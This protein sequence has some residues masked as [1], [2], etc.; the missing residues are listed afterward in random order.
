MN[1]PHGI[2]PTGKR[3]CRK[4]MRIVDSVKAMNCPHGTASAIDCT[5]CRPMIRKLG[6]QT[7]IW[8][9]LVGHKHLKRPRKET[10]PWC[11]ACGAWWDGRRWVLPASADEARRIMGGI[12]EWI[13]KQHAPPRPR[14][15]ALQ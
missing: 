7:A 4:C 6:R 8:D 3:T 11:G 10:R 2:D 5:K 1:C 12:L 14:R 15:K 9:M 13:D